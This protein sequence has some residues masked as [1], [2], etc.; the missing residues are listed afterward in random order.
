MYAYRNVGGLWGYGDS[1]DCQVNAAA[2]KETL[3]KIK[4]SVCRIQIGN[5]VCSGANKQH[6]GDCRPLVLSADPVLVVE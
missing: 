5:S 2:M 1:D 3:G 4:T 6:F